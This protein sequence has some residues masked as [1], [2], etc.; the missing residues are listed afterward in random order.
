MLEYC[1]LHSWT[2]LDQQQ[3]KDVDLAVDPRD[4]D[5]L[6]LSIR[7]CRQ[8]RIVQ[9]IH[10]RKGGFFLVFHNINEQNPILLPKV[11]H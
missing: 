11:S 3:N 5:S 7:N 10:Y 6:E 4:L 9:L 8:V 2:S 1:I